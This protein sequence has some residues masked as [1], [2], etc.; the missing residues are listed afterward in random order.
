MAVRELTV[1]VQRPNQS[2]TP[3]VS[4]QTSAFESRHRWKLASS[5]LFLKEFVYRTVPV[6]VLIFCVRCFAVETSH[7][8]CNMQQKTFT[9]HMTYVMLLFQDTIIGLLR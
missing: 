9:F 3:L 1:Q 8:H 4:F 6:V 2:I 5:T 7:H